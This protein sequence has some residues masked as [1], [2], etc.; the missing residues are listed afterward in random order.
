MFNFLHQSEE[1]ILIPVPGTWV[2]CQSV[3]PPPEINEKSLQAIDIVPH[4]YTPD[5]DDLCI[6][7]IMPTVLPFVDESILKEL[8]NNVQILAPIKG[9]KSP[10]SDKSSHGYRSGNRSSIVMC[11]KINSNTQITPNDWVIA[12]DSKDGSKYVI[13]LEHGNIAIRVKGCGMWTKK[14]D[15]PFPAIGVEDG[16]SRFA[17][18]DKKVINIRGVCY[19]S[20][21]CTEMFSTNQIEE[22]LN[23]VGLLCGNHSLGFWIYE[24]LQNDPAPLIT[25]TVSLFETLGDFRLESHLFPGLDLLLPKIVDEKLADQIIDLISPLYENM[26]DKFPSDSY[27]SIKKRQNVTYNSIDELKV[28]IKDLSFYKLTDYEF[29]SNSDDAFRQCGIIPTYEIYEKIKDL[30]KKF[31]DLVKIYGRIAFEVGRITGII[32]RSGNLWGTFIGHSPFILHNNS[33]TDNLIVLS[34]ETCLSQKRLQI[35]APV[36]FDMCFRYENTINYCEDP[37]FPSPKIFIYHVITEIDSMADCLAGYYAVYED[38]NHVFRQRKQPDGKLSNI[39]WLLRDCSVYE[40][41]QGYQKIYSNGCKGNDISVDSI[42]ELIN[43]ALSATFNF[44]S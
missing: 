24:N 37:P 25:K 4:K 30:D 10:Y 17:P 6:T 38:Q 11:R 44:N 43:E 32:H 39:M 16:I 5:N 2:S 23:K 14:N 35:V 1:V 26:K 18:K 7:P 31:V 28:K 34:K 8:R 21:A 13:D 22:N 33:H 36:D 3:S 15:I 40:Y 42:Y 41:Y 20:T 9:K 19:M 29:E 27:N 12:T